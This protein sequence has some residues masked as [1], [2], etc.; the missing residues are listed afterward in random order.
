MSL[1]SFDIKLSY[2]DSN[3][4]LCA[5][6]IAQ[7]DAV[8]LSNKR[9]LG[10]LKASDYHDFY[11]YES[12][13]AELIIQAETLSG[14]GQKLYKEYLNRLEK[15]SSEE[16]D[17]EEQAG[18]EEESPETIE[19]DSE[20]E[21]SKTIKP[22]ADSVLETKE[23]VSEKTEATSP[24]KSI[25]PDKVL[26]ML[27]EQ[28]VSFDIAECRDAEI[29]IVIS[30]DDLEA[31]LSISQ[32]FGGSNATEVSILAAL[33]KQAI[34][35]GIDKDALAKALESDTCSEV[36][37]ASGTRP[38]KGQDSK[39]EALVSEQ[40]F[41]APKVDAKGKVNYHDIN[42]FVIVEP[43][44]KLMRRTLP[45]KGTPG[46]DIFGK[47]IPSISGEVLPF[48][49]D[50]IGSKVS[51]ED[52]DLLVASAKGHPIVKSRGVSVE[53]VLILNNVGLSTG[54]VDFDGSVCVNED[55][56]DGIKIEASGD[57]TVKGAVGKATIIAGGNI[58]LLQGLLGGSTALQGM[59]E[60][61]YGAYLT[62][63]GSVSAH[64]VTHAKIRAAK[65]I[66]ITEYSSHSDLYAND[67][68]LLGQNGGKGNLFGG[69][70]RA[71]KL[72][73]AKVIGSAGGTPTN[74]KV[75]G[76][77]D[78]IV[79]LRRIGSEKRQNSENT[80]ELN[81][82]LHKINLLAKSAGMTPQTKEK[83][84]QLKQKLEILQAELH[85]LNKQEQAVKQILVKSKKSRVVANHQIYNNTSVT[86][87]GVCKKISE[88]TK[89]GTFKFEARKVVFEK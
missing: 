16:S 63:K 35:Y 33:K 37:I 61:P 58:V 17:K 45:G 3:R 57:V 69:H 47:V 12:S 13:I 18:L 49:G 28:Q 7:F 14:K 6:L 85:K 40:I 11:V 41:S 89:G 66:V 86:I 30:D 78:N 70:A 59:T 10:I 5:T 65:K 88:E 60:E 31:R 54:N 51:E 23:F 22:A 84:E 25:T 26:A 42:E 73:A 76:E 29:S 27:G 4:L 19:Q 56:A 71:F 46:I 52:Q 15:I 80:Y 8:P 34:T 48:S 67:Q 72:V 1:F 79:K 68:I 38:T 24:E 77:G 39:F 83:A 36:L 62:S 44:D 32:A 21:E 50:T 87:L 82:A 20:L 9:V 55:V 2:D 64:F 43:G 75:G 81:E 53:N 74:I